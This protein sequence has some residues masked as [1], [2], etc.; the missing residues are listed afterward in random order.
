MPADLR[1]HPAPGTLDVLQA[2]RPDTGGPMTP[3]RRL[4]PATT[5]VVLAAVLTLT[6]VATMGTFAWRAHQLRTS[7]P[8]TATTATADEALPACDNATFDTFPCREA[9]LDRSRTVFTGEDGLPH[10]ACT[11]VVTSIDSTRMSCRDGYAEPY[12][13]PVGGSGQAP[14]DSP[15]TGAGGQ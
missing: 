2:S 4:W 7:T 5:L 9:T 1:T 13:G 12:T 3:H 14:I 6:A 15:V 10:T 11:V 8:A